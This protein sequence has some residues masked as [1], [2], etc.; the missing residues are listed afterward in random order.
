MNVLN[1]IVWSPS[2]YVDAAFLARLA[3]EEML[4]RLDWMTIKPKVIV[5]VGC[6][7]GEMSQQLQSRYPNAQVL[8]LDASE[9]M[10]GWAKQQRAQGSYLCAEAASLPFADHAVEM[11]FVNF[12][13]SWQIDFDAFLREC[14]RVLA[15]EGLLMI[16]AIGPDTLCTW[17][18]KL[19]SEHLPCFMDMHDLG[20][21]LLKV[22][23]SDPVV[24]V[25]GYTA[26]YK[27]ASRF[28]HE[29]R[30]SGFWF[31][32]AETLRAVEAAAQDDKVEWYTEVIYAHAFAPALSNEVG[33]SDDGIARFPLS[34]LRRQLKSG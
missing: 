17:R 2:D 10:L 33:M 5:D 18:D 24:D 12:V 1:N 29:L 8:S 9:T 11:L 26:C 6:G 20:D 13:L 3:G 15:P 28:L 34:H 14:K 32:D 19:Q 22:G 16:N 27:Q 4:S 7:A 21:L 30:A 23:F 25:D 31:P